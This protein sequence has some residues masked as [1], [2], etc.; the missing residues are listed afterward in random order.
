[1]MSKDEFAD[2]IH[3]FLG[4]LS[5]VAASN[6]PEDLA[7]LLGFS[8]ELREAREIFQ[9]RRTPSNVVV[10]TAVGLVDEFTQ[11]SWDDIVTKAYAFY[12]DRQGSVNT[13]KTTPGR[14]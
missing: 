2:A 9:D 6:S 1:M 11:R 10:S 8:A 13:K 14:A 7:R 3:S 4:E 12:V 5:A